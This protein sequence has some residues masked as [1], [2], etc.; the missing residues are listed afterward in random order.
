[1]S[2]VFGG[3]RLALME[4]DTDGQTNGHGTPPPLPSLTK[5]R[6]PVRTKRVDLD[7][8]YE[9]WWAEVRTNAPFGVFLNMMEMLSGGDDTDNVKVAR[10][11]GELIASLPTLVRN[12]NF[13]DEEGDPLP[14]DINGMRRIPQD[15]LLV[16]LTAMQKDETVPKD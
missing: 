11:M 13:V 12:W 6:M 15:L 1:M 2:G 14:C 9:G 5:R 10:A 3:E 4:P 7:G 16:L 8:D